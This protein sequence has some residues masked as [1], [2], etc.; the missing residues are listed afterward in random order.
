[1][2]KTKSSLTKVAR[3]VAYGDVSNNAV[4]NI[5]TEVSKALYESFT[6]DDMV[7][8]MKYFNWCCPYT[9]RYLKDD[10]DSK[11]GN[12]A[13]DHIYP[14]NRVWCGLNVVGNLVLVDKKANSKKRDQS[15]DDFLLHDTEALGDLDEKIRM[16]RLQKIKKFQEEKK[17]DPERIKTTISNLMKKRYDEVRKEQETY[18]ADALVALELA[19]IFVQN[20]D[21]SP[22]SKHKDTKELTKS[23]GLDKRVEDE[24]KNYLIEECGYPKTT[25][26]SYR[27]GLNKILKELEMSDLHELEREINRAIDVCSTR[28]EDAKN[29]GDKKR[30]KN[31]SDLRSALKKY[32]DFIEARN[33]S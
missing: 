19:G 6:E 18:I 17:Y 32:K 4:R 20:D 31:Y 26:D 12:Y 5:L 24:F 2:G 16:E 9:G 11:N 7:E 3:G 23:L 25:A 1:M 29:S 8:T 13:T 22:V 15:V 10:Y 27:S 14:Q 33:K 30:V 21:A 28:R